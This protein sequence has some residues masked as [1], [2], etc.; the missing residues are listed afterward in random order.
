MLIHPLTAKKAVIHAA[1]VRRPHQPMLVCKQYCNQCEATKADKSQTLVPEQEGKNTHHR[2]MQEA[3]YPEGPSHPKS[4]GNG[5]ER[6]APVELH[7]LARID[8]VESCYPQ[9]HGGPQ[10]ERHGGQVPAHGDP[11]A[12]R[13]TREGNAEEEVRTPRKALCVRIGKHNRQSDRTQPEGQRIEHV[14]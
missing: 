9:H 13:G 10:E 1:Q 14:G 6:L 3:R 11:G 12:N 5:V 2:H 4:P 8:D 7:I